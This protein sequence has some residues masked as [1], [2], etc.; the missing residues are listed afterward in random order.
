VSENLDT[1]VERFL[2]HKR[3][4][5]SRLRHLRPPCRLRRRLPP[6]RRAALTDPQMIRTL[7]PRVA[8]DNH[9]ATAT[10]QPTQRRQS[11]A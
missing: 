10:L 3:A 2:A 7:V 1:A 9:H 6:L 11:S 4:T 8:V 5:L